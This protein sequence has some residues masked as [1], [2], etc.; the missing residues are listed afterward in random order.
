[1]GSTGVGSGSTSSTSGSGGAS[2]GSSGTGSLCQ[3]QRCT[4]YAQTNSDLYTIDPTTSAPTHVGTFGG[5]LLGAPVFDIAVRDDGALYAISASNLYTVD[6]TTAV[7][8]AVATLNPPYNFNS[9]TFTLSG[10]LLAADAA[11]GGVY[12]IEPTTGTVTTVGNFGNGL[13]PRPVHGCRDA[14]S[15]QRG[16][17]LV[18]RRHDPRSSPLPVIPARR[19]R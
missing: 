1:M 9:L 13:D 16:A 18:W 11:T 4:I 7:G 12:E 5:A 8:T 10:T 14:S 15:R 19:A 17:G 2:G 3:T 6:P